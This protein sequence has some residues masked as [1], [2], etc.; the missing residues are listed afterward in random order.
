MGTALTHV[1]P[2]SRRS[3][4]LARSYAQRF[5]QLRW[6][7]LLRREDPYVLWG[8]NSMLW[9]ILDEDYFFGLLV[10]TDGSTNP[11]GVRV[12][13]GD[14]K[15]VD[16]APLT[17]ISIK[18]PVGDVTAV[19][20][21]SFL[22]GL[23]SRRPELD[24]RIFGYDWRLS[25]VENARKLRAFV[26]DAW[27]LD[28]RSSN[29]DER[30]SIVAHSMGG[31]V[32]RAC[33]ESPELRG[34]R[35]VKQLITV[36]TPHLGSPVV[37]SHM[38]GTSFP[39]PPLNEWLLS[40]R[41]QQELTLRLDSVAEM[42]PVFDFVAR[43]EAGGRLEPW[44]STLS[45]LTL[46]RYPDLTR[47]PRK[48][49]EALPV[50][51]AFREHL[52][53]EEELQAWCAWRRVRYLFL[54]GNG[55]YTTTGL[56]RLPGGGRA[57]PKPTLSGDATVPYHSALAFGATARRTARDATAAR[58]TLRRGMNQHPPLNN[59]EWLVRKAF[60]TERRFP[61]VLTNPDR[62]GH[63]DAMKIADV[64][65]EI[66]RQFGPS[67]DPIP[68]RPRWSMLMEISWALGLATRRQIGPEVMC[69]AVLRLRPGDRPPLAY[70]VRHCTLD[71][72]PM[73]SALQRPHR[74]CLAKRLPATFPDVYPGEDGP[75]SGYSRRYLLIDRQV[76]ADA[77]HLGG[78]AVLLDEHPA[79]DELF[80][81][82]W[83]TGELTR[84]VRQRNKHHAEGHLA[85]WWLAQ[86]K[87]WRDRLV[88]VDV[89]VTHSPCTF[90]CADLRRLTGTEPDTGVESATVAWF[91]LY[92][93]DR[94]GVGAT[95]AEALRKLTHQKPPWKIEK[96]RIN[97]VD[98]ESPTPRGWKLP[99]PTVRG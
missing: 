73:L 92:E 47:G 8:R 89:T 21:D 2:P 98:Y 27:D 30:V 63:D 4:E 66:A 19:P 32:A 70:V 40:R 76:E 53:P 55:K 25:N 93:G 14:S 17:R 97:M 67:A 33:I 29:G 74:E 9:F 7:S 49:V 18:F 71:Q 24:V 51:L 50:V 1:A 87:A 36:A 45:E 23:T 96:R 38:N 65:H 6:S 44:R 75:R 20:Y 84:S 26:L 77:A 52:V 3:V 72:R 39:F 91:Q 37:F 57:T 99:S 85:G 42:L 15:S 48:D 60:D 58:E 82:T 94:A 41:S 86:D 22:D 69:A 59:T 80:V 12:L 28:S 54:G 16:D 68:E 31:L 46:H 79:G 88:S 5:P 83:N 43:P 11:G 61:Y 78:G 56:V 13:P 35:F 10:D 64:E 62:I 81:V 95:N 90:C 34:Y